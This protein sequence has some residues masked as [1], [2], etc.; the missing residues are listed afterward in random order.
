[1]E[2]LARAL[3]DYLGRLARIIQREQEFTANASHEL[4]TPLTAIRTSCELL[5]ADRA[6]PEKARTRVEMMNTAA[7]RMEEQI[8]TLLFLARE[9][10]I[11]AVEPVSIR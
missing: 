4:R 2:A 11:G 3:D 7:A 1:V 8:Q 9:M 5:L 10:S 6:L